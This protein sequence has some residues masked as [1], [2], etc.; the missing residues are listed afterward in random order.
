MWVLKVICGTGYIHA[1]SLAAT[2]DGSFFLAGGRD[3]SYRSCRFAGP[4]R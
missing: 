1:P 3:D 2:L 4:A